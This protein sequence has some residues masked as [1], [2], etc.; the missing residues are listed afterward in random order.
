MT[1]WLDV[2]E[3]EKDE[4]KDVMFSGWELQHRMMKGKVEAHS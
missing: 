1:H 3:I 2:W 4:D